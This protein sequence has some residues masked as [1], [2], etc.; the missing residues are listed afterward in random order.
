MTTRF[1][2]L[3]V[4]SNF[5]L[6]RGASSVE[7]LVAR[8]AKLGYRSL[9]LTD[10]DALYGAIRF[11][12]ACVSAG[13]RP[14]LGSEVTL[15][16]GHHLILLAENQDGYANLCRLISRAHENQPKGEAVLP[17]DA[18]AERV[19]GLIALSGP[20]TG[21]I[22]RLLLAGRRTE[23]VRAA[24]SYRDVFGDRFYMEIQTHCLPDDGWLM[25]ELAALGKACQIDLV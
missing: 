1:A 24:N 3:H 15:E 18:L 19:D 22:P 9:A 20:R 21:E 5:S 14:I 6:L 12:K 4:H 25:A 2:P 16:G 23:A 17:F 10:R 7:D 8:A 13:L 11:T